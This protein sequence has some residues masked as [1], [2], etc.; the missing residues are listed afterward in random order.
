MTATRMMVAEEMVATEMIAATMEIP[1]TMTMGMA[2][3]ATILIARTKMHVCL[4]TTHLTAATA[5]N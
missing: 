5:K 3:T 1:M 4:E 2:G